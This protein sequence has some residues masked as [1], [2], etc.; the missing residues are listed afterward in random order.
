[1]L[2]IPLGLAAG[3]RCWHESSVSK[4]DAQRAMREAKYAGAPT[5]ATRTPKASV[6][7]AKETTEGICGHRSIGNKSCQRPPGHPEQSHRYK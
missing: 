7:K 6:P 1:M 4:L 3:I 2:R 5:P